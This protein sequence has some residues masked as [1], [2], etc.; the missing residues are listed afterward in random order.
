MFFEILSR[1]VKALDEELTG[2]NDAEAVA[3]RLMRLDELYRYIQFIVVLE[4]IRQPAL[5]FPAPWRMIKTWRI[6]PFIP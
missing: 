6:F 4:D 2:I 3:S 5:P 1:E